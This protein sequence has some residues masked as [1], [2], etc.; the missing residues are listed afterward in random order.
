MA[1]DSD[2]ASGS[3][4]ASGSGT[5]AAPVGD[6]PAD[7]T[8]S[9]RS[10]ALVLSVAG[11]ALVLVGALIGLL[12]GQSID[13]SNLP[14]T[15]TRPAADS[16]DVG[17][18]HDMTVHHEQGVL[19]GHIVQGLG[20]SD[21]VESLGYDIEY[22]QTSQI[23]QMG[24]FLALWDYPLSS[25]NTPMS[26][27]TVHDMAGMADMQMTVDP[28][29]AAQG[30][31]MPGMA[32]NAEI[33]QLKSLSGQAAGTYFLQLMIRHHQGGLPMMTYAA[34]HAE[35]PVV[36]TMS[37]KMA[38]AQEKEIQ[39]MTQML[40]EVG[41]VPLPAPGESSAGAATPTATSAEATSSGHEGHGAPASAE[42]TDMPGMSGMT[43]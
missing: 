31:V 42:M 6:P 4:A 21:V 1:R 7:P 18:L 5:H 38:E 16:V 19:M 8:G 30:A 11:S 26:W 9:R 14:Q 36:R 37:Q 12:I 43:G 28:A 13:N 20:V 17:F 22:Q 10:P 33:Q 40:A 41:A 35:N 2:T 29:A 39:I 27:M 3:D 24:G 15:M 32:T 34:E 23:G 25:S